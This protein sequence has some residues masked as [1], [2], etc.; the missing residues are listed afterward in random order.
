MKQKRIIQ[1]SQKHFS[2]AE[3]HYI[4]QELIETQC[5]KAQ[6]WE[7][8][9]GQEEEHGQLLRWM[10]QLG[11]H[12]LILRHSFSKS[13]NEPESPQCRCRHCHF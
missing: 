3:K 2:E 12:E 7:K 10:K 6:I 4:I 5:T 11:I 1:K 8:Y 13:A 9:T